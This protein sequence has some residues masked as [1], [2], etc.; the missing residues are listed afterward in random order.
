[1][2]QEKIPHRLVSSK[3]ASIKR[4]N[5]DGVPQSRVKTIVFATFC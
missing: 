5:K 1:M 2:I 3:V 4:L